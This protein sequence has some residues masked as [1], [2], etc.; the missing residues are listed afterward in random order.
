MINI[1]EDS[2]DQDRDEPE[3]IP[4]PMTGLSRFSV[5]ES[6]LVSETPTSSKYIRRSGYGKTA[7]NM[8]YSAKLTATMPLTREQQY[9]EAMRYKPKPALETSK[10]YRRSLYKDIEPLSSRKS[11]YTVNRPGR[12]TYTNDGMK[13]LDKS[14]LT[15]EEYRLFKDFSTPLRPKRFTAAGEY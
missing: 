8:D 4:E 5:T 13:Y 1:Q 6:G 15:D 7:R 10:Y 14:R 9:E 3:F 11:A 12:S 2:Y